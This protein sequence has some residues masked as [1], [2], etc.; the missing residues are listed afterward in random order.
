[1]ATN[2]I[3][4]YVSDGVVTI[5]SVDFALGYINKAHVYVYTS[6][7]E[8][9]T[10]LS[11]TWLNNSQIELTTPVANG[12]ELN[13]R[14]VVPRGTPVNDY[15]NGAILREVNLDTSFK[16]ALMI[17]EEIGDG[18]FTLDE[19]A[20]RMTSDLD[21]NSYSI[22]NLPI[23][24]YDSDPVRLTDLLNAELGVFVG[25]TRS[26]DSVAALASSTLTIGEA[27]QTTGYYTAGDGGGATYIVSATAVGDGIANH[28]L[29]GGGVAE[30]ILNAGD[31]NLKQYGR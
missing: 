6:D 3:R 18:F 9:T 25:Y 1:M 28:T 24:T 23:P 22:R 14:R 30:L 27:V 29:A 21:M 13:I 4:T 19:T 11:Y 10:Q 2:T 16:Q 5:Y 20:L 12:V 15:E 7:N 31:F 17:Q 8:Y 26:F